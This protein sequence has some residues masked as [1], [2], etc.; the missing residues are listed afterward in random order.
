MYTLFFPSLRSYAW[1]IEMIRPI[2]ILF[3]K[4]TLSR[5]PPL[6]RFFF[7]QGYFCNNGFILEKLRRNDLVKKS[8]TI[9]PWQVTE[10]FD[11]KRMCL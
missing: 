8:H 11:E 7:I 9:V 4:Q 10:I 1:K 2:N 3:T 5:H 6:S